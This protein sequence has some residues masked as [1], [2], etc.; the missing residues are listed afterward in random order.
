MTDHA[1][2]VPWYCNRALDM[3]CGQPGGDRGSRSS[4]IEHSAKWV[5]RSQSTTGGLSRRNVGDRRSLERRQ[6]GETPQCHSVRPNFR[7]DWNVASCSIS[8]I[9]TRLSILCSPTFA[10]VIH[11]LCSETGSKI[12]FISFKKAWHQLKIYTLGKNLMFPLFPGE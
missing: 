9:K 7:G 5:A 3:F 8:N 2:S 10:D 11:F 1:L 12:N 6:A 4:L